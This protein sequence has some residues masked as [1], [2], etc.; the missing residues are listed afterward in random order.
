MAENPSPL[1]ESPQELIDTPNYSPSEW[2]ALSG[3]QKK[4]E[5]ARNQ[6]EQAWDEFD[7]MS[8][9]RYCEE[10]R[11][12]ANSYIKPRQNAEETNFVTGTTRQKLLAY[13]AAVNNLD[14]APDIQAF[15]EDNRL[16][17]GIGEDLEDAIF[18][19]EELDHDEEKKLLRQYTMFEQGTVFVEEDWKIDRRKLKTLSKNIKDYHGEVKGVEWSERMKTVYAGPSRNVVKNENVY[20]GDCR[21]FFMDQQPFIFTVEHKSYD[22][23]KSIYG[24]WERWKFVPRKRTD[25]QQQPDSTYNVNWRLTAP[26]EGQVEI[27]KYQNIWDDEFQIMI[28]GVLMLP[29]GFPLSAVFPYGK[30]SIEKQVLEVI[31]SHFAY[32]KSFPSRLKVSQGLIDEMMR[33]AI[34]K[35]Q[36]SFLPPRANETGRVL[37]SKVFFPG[38]ITSGINP[39][40]LQP[41][42]DT[43]GM[44]S[45]ESSMIQMLFQNMDENSVDPTTQGQSAKG[46]P[47]ATEI[48]ALK[49]QAEKML[50]ITVFVAA[51]LEKKLACLRLYNILQHYFEPY[52]ERVDSARQLLLKKYRSV[53]RMKPIDGQGMGMKMVRIAPSDRTPTPEDIYAEEEQLSKGLEMPVRISYLDPEVVA[54]ARYEWYVT[55]TPKPRKTSDL[56]RAVWDQALQRLMQFPNANLEYLGQRTAEK[57]EENPE[58]VFK[59][60]AEPVAPTEPGAPTSPLPGVPQLRNQATTGQMKTE[61]TL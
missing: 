24:D 48:L 29:L 46:S 6:R 35:T 21:Q 36:Q 10:N 20:L 41:L 61:G 37:S 50:G 26:D 54:S 9:T 53:V 23:A 51:M 33:L 4:L 57:W 19:S 8:L 2:S 28:N 30:Y 14:L 15:D 25:V 22:E 59:K 17:E 38:K 40:K 34:L 11:K 31:S 42:V 16:V 58:K 27:I 52:D 56:A 47:T 5:G 12:A 60:T 45:A 13:L 49:Q 39:S 55:I 7:G 3:F 43:T 32:G 44:T 18:R 1:I